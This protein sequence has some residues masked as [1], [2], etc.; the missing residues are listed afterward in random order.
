MV[1]GTKAKS[2]IKWGAN[3]KDARLI[4]KIAERAITR[5]KAHGIDAEKIDVVMDIE[6]CH[7]N[8]CRLRLAELLATDDFNFMHDITGINRHLDRTTGEL[9]NCFLPRFAAPRAR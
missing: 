6:A 1:A 8:G 9:T 2:A 5:Y 4:A 3:P 7:L